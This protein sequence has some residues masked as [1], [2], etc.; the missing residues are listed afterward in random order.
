MAEKMVVRCRKTE[1]M[2]LNLC[3]SDQSL[4]EKIIKPADMSQLAGIKPHDFPQLPMAQEIAAEWFQKKAGLFRVDAFHSENEAVSPLKRSGEIDC[5]NADALPNEFPDEEFVSL[6]RVVAQVQQ[7]ISKLDILIGS[8]E[9]KMEKMAIQL[10]LGLAKMTMKHSVESTPDGVLNNLSQILKRC[11]GRNV[12]RI[13]L[14]PADVEMVHASRE[15]WSFLVEHVETLE[16]KADTRIGRGGC[17]LE[18][19]YGSIDASLENQFQV[20]KGHMKSAMDAA[21]SE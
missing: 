3:A 2:S 15:A 6:Q 5:A 4:R 10:S 17:V 8:M 9:T 16:L 14:N 21:R 11:R 1:D 13:R 19:G 18:T 20:L 7:A 12:R